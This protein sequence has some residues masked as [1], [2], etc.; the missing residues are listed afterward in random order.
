MMA[1]LVVFCRRESGAGVGF[2]SGDVR[3]PPLCLSAAAFS[4]AKEHVKAHDHGK[5]DDK[6]PNFPRNANGLAKRRDNHRSQ[7]QE[8]GEYLRPGIARGHDQSG[9]NAFTTFQSSGS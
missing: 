7:Q 5:P 4:F 1:L 6:F 9:A 2:R 3:V 8:N